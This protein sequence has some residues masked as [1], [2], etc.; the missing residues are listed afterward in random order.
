MVERLVEFLAWWQ[1]HDELST[2]AS[3]KPPR[4]EGGELP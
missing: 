1:A 3:P 2:P 4:G